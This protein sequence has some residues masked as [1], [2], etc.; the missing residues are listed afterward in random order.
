M[1]RI[2]LVGQTN[3]GKTLFTLNF[4]AYL[5]LEKVAITFGDSRSC[6]TQ[7]F[8]VPEAL[9]RFVSE[10]KHHTR[11]LQAVTFSLPKGKVRKYWQ[12]IDSVGLVDQIHPCPAVRQAMAHTLSVIPDTGHLL[13]M[14][15][16]SRPNQ[17]SLLDRQLAQFG[18]HCQSYAIIANKVDLLP[19]SSALNQLQ[20]MFPDRLILPVSA[21]HH[22]G[23]K[24]VKAHVRCLL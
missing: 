5:G 21:L 12:L 19:N 24:E 14:V 3:V 1:K 17:V 10:Q 6:Y 16:A 4:A 11:S 22:T 15:D 9:S 23:F 20:T 2:L 18:A 13:H 8:S 7:E